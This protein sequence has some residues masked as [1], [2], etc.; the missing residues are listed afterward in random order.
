MDGNEN[1]NV[2]L[3]DLSGRVIYS[4]KISGVN[5]FTVS[6]SGF[7]SGTYLLSIRNAQGIGTAKVIVE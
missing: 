6:T 2:E 4:E 5:A 3:A 7:S 1:T